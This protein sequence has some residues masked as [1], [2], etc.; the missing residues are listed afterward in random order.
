MGG[1]KFIF[2]S[3]NINNNVML[4]EEESAFDFKQLWT[5]F[6]SNWHWIIGL[7]LSNASRYV[8]RFGFPSFQL[9]Y[10]EPEL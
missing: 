4:E 5:L 10:F 2:M 8:R 1:R 7:E 6:L 9:G 3:E